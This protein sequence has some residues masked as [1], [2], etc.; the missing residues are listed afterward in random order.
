MARK[1]NASLTADCPLCNATGYV[2]SRLPGR[3][4]LCGECGGR[5]RVTAVKREQVLKRM[6][7][8]AP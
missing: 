1:P 5:A 4:K 8:L 3:K 2:E 6:K 7:R